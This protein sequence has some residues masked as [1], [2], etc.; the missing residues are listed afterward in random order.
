MSRIIICIYFP[1]QS[2]RPR[3]S[4]TPIGL[5]KHIV[6]HQDLDSAD[7]GWSTSTDV[8]SEEEG[9]PA[10]HLAAAQW[11]KKQRAHATDDMLD[12]DTAFVA[13]TMRIVPSST[14]KQT[15]P[16]APAQK[17]P[18]E[19]MTK[20]QR[21]NAAKKAKAKAEKAELEQQQ[22]AALRAH[23]K[24]LEARR[25]AEITRRDNGSFK[26]PAS[27]SAWNADEWKEVTKHKKVSNGQNASVDSN[28][29]LIWE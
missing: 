13:R 27:S 26:P 7:G 17:K 18:E 25:L 20:K 11:Q 14:P 23:T 24:N 8:V 15:K 22:A 16:Q 5:Q 6:K 2:R 9:A 19:T 21:Q 3:K 4:S 12:P 10:T 29:K 28:G 1:D